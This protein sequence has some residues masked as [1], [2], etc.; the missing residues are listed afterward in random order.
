MKP[1][2]SLLVLVAVPLAAQETPSTVRVSGYI[3]PRFQSSGDSAAFFLRRARVGAEGQV[4][5]WASFRAQVEMRTDDAPVVP[6]ES[7]L[8][9]SATDLFVR[10]TG[11]RWTATIGQS[12]VPFS[13]EGLISA[14]SLEVSERS[15]ASDAAP[16]RDIGVTLEWRLPQRVLVQAAMVNG[17]GPNR[18]TNPDNRMAYFARVVVTPI[19]GAGLDVGGAAAGY[20]DSTHLDLQ[21]LFQRGR[22][23]A[24]AEWLRG[25]RAATGEH[26][27]G[28]YALGAYLVRPPTLQLVVRAERFDPSDQ[29]SGDALAGYSVGA[30]YLIRGDNLKVIAD[31]TTFREQGAQL[32]NDRAAAQLQVRF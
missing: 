19:A 26:S 25:R 6:I 22:V 24:R 10:L 1:L 16:L 14:A 12:K 15:L 5:P 7:P 29:A 8:T 31:Y 3:Q 11:G 13:L 23:R 20:A 4:T 27:E 17:E 30:Q 9:I 28:W 21:A 18:V 2:L 32:N